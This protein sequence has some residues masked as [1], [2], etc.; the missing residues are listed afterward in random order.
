MFFDVHGEEKVKMKIAEVRAKAKAMGVVAG[1]RKKADLIR[2]I[3]IE[4]GNSPCFGASGESC[5]QQDCCWRD[6][7]IGREVPCDAERVRRPLKG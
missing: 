2:S 7:C 5:D 4:E 6:D 3:Q 1:G